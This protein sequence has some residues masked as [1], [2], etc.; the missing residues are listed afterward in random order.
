[1]NDTFTTAVV[2]GVLTF[3]HAAGGAALGVALRGRSWLLAAW[4]LVIGASPCYFG[5]EQGVKRGA[6]LPL[7]WQVGVLVA[8]AS[9]MNLPQAS[10]VSR[11]FLRSGMNGLMIGTFIMAA[12][13]VTAAWLVRQGAEI[14]S[15]V[16]GGIGFLFGAMWFGAG[17]KQLRGK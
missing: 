1:M 16:V 4:G 17:I 11:F 13:A 10:R 3:F 9:A 15:Q 8:C 6:W 2:F 12:S 7:A 14:G 5:I